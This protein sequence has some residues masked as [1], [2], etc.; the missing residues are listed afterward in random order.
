MMSLADWVA[1]S[2]WSLA[3]TKAGSSWLLPWFDA[4][5]R[6]NGS[7]LADFPEAIA[8][9]AGREESEVLVSALRV[10][11][12]EALEAAA[13]AGIS[14]V[15][16]GD[17]AYPPLLAAIPDPPVVIWVRGRAAALVEPAVAVV[18]SRAGS[19]Y[20]L[21]VAGRLAEDLA[22]AGAAVV[23]GLARG[24]DSAAHRG[25]LAAGGLTIAVLGSGLLRVY[26]PEHRRLAET[27]ADRGAVVSEW[28][29]ATPPRPPN[30]PARN[31]IISGLSLGVVVIEAAERSG[32][33]I[34]AGFAL[35]QGR[36]VMAVPGSVLTGRYRGCH[37]LIRD[38]AA[39][40]ESAEDVIACLRDSPLRLVN[41]PSEETDAS[42]PPN[43]VLSLLAPGEADDID[44]LAARSGL[45]PASLLP[46]LLE[47]E[48]QGAVRRVA[49]GRF[50]RVGRTC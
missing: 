16:W 38:G 21:E 4:R 36:E 31:R 13:K 29:P 34:T 33:L 17:P 42:D 20:G 43:P 30:F 26:P 11:A 8:A 46:R 7:P 35:E 22:A 32:S 44:T 15:P 45:K 47:L 5:S 18:G 50:V 25:A 10:E 28:P 6:P 48:L 23:S 27:I 3:R 12:A 1:L 14:A 9:A 37:A 39:V 40:V 2:F 49:G 41:R 19:A 24:V